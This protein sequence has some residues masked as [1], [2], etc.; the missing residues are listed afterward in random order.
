MNI[1]N[2]KTNSKITK[3]DLKKLYLSV[4]WT[5]Y[6]DNIDTLKKAVDNS[7]YVISAWN[8]NELIG[9]IR[10]IGDGLTIIYIQ[11]I[12][13]KPKYENKGIGTN[14]IQQILNKYRDVRQKVLITDENPKTRKFY[15]KNGFISTD[16]GSIVGFYQFD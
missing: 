9:L 11:D 1:I 2:Y 6:T 5:S 16:K 4:S 13:V 15:E 8:E 3:Y 7:L 10:I 12:I 14:L